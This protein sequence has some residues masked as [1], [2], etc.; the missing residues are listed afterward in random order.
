[1]PT[2]LSHI[3]FCLRE[4]RDRRN[5]E[6]T[7]AL[8]AKLPPNRTRAQ[9]R[10]ENDLFTLILRNLSEWEAQYAQQMSEYHGDQLIH[11]NDLA[12]WLTQ[13]G[14]TL[15]L[16]GM[17]LSGVDTIGE[18][19]LSYTLTDRAHTS[20]S[21]QRLEDALATLVWLVGDLTVYE[22]AEEETC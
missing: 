8:R 15:T 5:A 13:D 10:I 6:N 12:T 9:E 17:R 19:A 4:M 7:A 3:G 16:N 1:M 22:E 14:D 2:L 11:L 20:H 21:F 18:D